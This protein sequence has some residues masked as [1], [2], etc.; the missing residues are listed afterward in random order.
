MDRPHQHEDVAGAERGGLFVHTGFDKVLG[1]SRSHGCAAD[2]PMQ[3]GDHR[4]P[5]KIGRAIS[6]T[7]MVTT[8]HGVSAAQPWLRDL[9]APCRTPCGRIAR[10]RSAP[11][12]SSCLVK[13]YPYGRFLALDANSGGHGIRQGPLIRGGRFPRAYAADGDLYM[14]WHPTARFG[15][16][17][18]SMRLRARCAGT[19]SRRPRAVGRPPWTTTSLRM[20]AAI[21]RDAGPSRHAL[22]R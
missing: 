20:D 8:L 9:P 2:T 1:K 22:P 14:A 5:K 13:A 6:T 12:T 19:C 11:A 15:R 7:A 4:R 3:R 16:W 21:H 10:L 18:I 17:L